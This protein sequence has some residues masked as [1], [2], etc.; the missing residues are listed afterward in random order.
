MQLISSGSTPA[1]LLANE[2]NCALRVIATVVS[3]PLPGRAAIDAGSK[4]LTSD[5]AAHREGYGYVVGLQGVSIS[6]LNEEHGFIEFDP[7]EVSLKVGDRLE[8]IP[9]HSCVIPNL[10][11]FINGVRKG[12]VT[13]SIKVDARGRNY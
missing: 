2:E 12:K 4:T 10:Y 13:E 1:S 3:K 6:A 5:K 9:N 11:D 8:I 7:E